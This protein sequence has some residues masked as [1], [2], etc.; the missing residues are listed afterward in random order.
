METKKNK[1]LKFYQNLGKLFYAIAA[2]D[3]NVREAEVNK[4]KGI[5]K[6]EW[7]NID[8]IE[9]EFGTDAAYQVEV[10]FDWLTKEEDFDAKACYDDFV[11]YKNDQPYLFTKKVKYLILRTANAIAASFSGMNKSEL[12]LLAKLT[13]ELNKEES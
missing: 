8:D 9:D 13:I 1:T 10:V 12:M 7:L 5:V 11:A 3:K 4:L 2:A 6:K